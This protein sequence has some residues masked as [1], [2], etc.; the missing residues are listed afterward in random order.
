VAPIAWTP[1][2]LLLISCSLAPPTKILPHQKT[3]S[4][5]LLEEGSLGNCSCFLL[6]ESVH[7]LRRKQ[8]AS[9]DNRQLKLQ[10]QA[11]KNLEITKNSSCCRRILP[12]TKQA[13]F[14]SFLPSFLPSSLSPKSSQHTQADEDQKIQNTKLCFKTGTQNTI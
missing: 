2:N 9:D 13:Q 8:Q 14:S 12:P 6:E 1:R 5:F 3:C 11:A 4:C 10:K 7:S